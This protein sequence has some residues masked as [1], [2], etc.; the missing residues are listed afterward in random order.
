MFFIP[1]AFMLIATL[2]QLVLTVKAKLAAVSHYDPASGPLWGHYFQL[3]FAAA[4][5][6]LAVILVIEGIGTFAKQSAKKN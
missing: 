2:T 3:I 6:I 5:I 4:M 1:M